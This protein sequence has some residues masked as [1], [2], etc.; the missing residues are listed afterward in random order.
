MSRSES[1]PR[2]SVRASFVLHPCYIR[3]NPFGLS[4]AIP[5]LDRRA[6]RGRCPSLIRRKSVANPLLEPDA[7]QRKKVGADIA[8]SAPGA[9]PK[10][11]VGNVQN[12]AGAKIRH[13]FVPVK[14]SYQ[15]FAK[16]RVENPFF[17]IRDTPFLY[18]NLASKPT[19]DNEKKMNLVLSISD[20][21]EGLGTM[22][23]ALKL[24]ASGLDDVANLLRDA[25]KGE[26][27]E[28]K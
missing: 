15:Q 20:I 11:W 21:A 26:E 16:N 5:S 17:R 8:L 27:A 3:A 22:I 24:T 18:F 28:L 25:V 7:N 13:P 19:M 23:D 9:G 10:G 2:E 6:I 1:E 12:P 14:R 4:F